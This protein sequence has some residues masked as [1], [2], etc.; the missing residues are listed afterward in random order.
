MFAERKT[1]SKLGGVA[2]HRAC[3]QLKPNSLGLFDMSG[4][5]WEWT[6]TTQ[7]LSSDFRPVRGGAWSS[8][9]IWNCRAASCCLENRTTCKS[10]IGFRIV[11]EVQ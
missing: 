1:S 7:S 8:T 6:E 5:L 2:Q 10:C 3:G 9:S 11:A 4:N